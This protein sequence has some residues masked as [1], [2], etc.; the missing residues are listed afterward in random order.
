MGLEKK[1]KASIAWLLFPFFGLWFVFWL[2]PLFFGVDL[3]LQ[4]PGYIP[5]YRD[6]FEGSGE[7]YSGFQF[8]WMDSQKNEIEEKESVKYIGLQNFSRVLADKKFYKALKTVE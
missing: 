2:V 8:N 4:N 3:A 7:E 5:E 6:A 1:E